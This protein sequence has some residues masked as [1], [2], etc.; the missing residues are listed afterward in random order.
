M[1]LH[2]VVDV[3]FPVSV[4]LRV[5]NSAQ[6]HILDRAETICAFS[7]ERNR[8]GRLIFRRGGRELSISVM[9]STKLR[10]ATSDAGADVKVAFHLELEVIIAILF[11]ASVPAE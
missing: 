2:V 11:V 4:V 9:M 1:T 3:L 8:G 10:E 7:C 6:T 5:W